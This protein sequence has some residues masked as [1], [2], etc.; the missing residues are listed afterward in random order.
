[1]KKNAQRK[2]Y[3]LIRLFVISF[4][5]MLLFF[6]ILIKSFSPSVDVSIGDYK[7]E[8]D[9]E[10]KMVN[11]DDRLTAIQDEDQ[12]KSFTEL[13]KKAEGDILDETIIGNMRILELADTKGIEELEK[14]Y[15][16]KMPAKRKAFKKDISTND[17]IEEAAEKGR[18]EELREASRD[19]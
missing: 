9:I 14:D 10:E 18:E 17:Q 7:Q 16:K 15:D 3:S 1:M 5:G 8:T 12:G 11:V 13:M 19:N 6:T 4:F 2:D